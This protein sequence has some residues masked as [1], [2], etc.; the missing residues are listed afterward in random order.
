MAND[1]NQEIKVDPEELIELEFLEC[2][3]RRI[4]DDLCLLRILAGAYTKVGRYE[5]GL[6]LDLKLTQLVPEDALVWYNYGCSLALVQH[7]NEAL[8]ALAHAIALG[9][10]NA[11]WMSKDE[12]LRSLK[13]DKRFHFLLK[14]ISP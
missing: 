4:P 12:D 2:L 5:A 14:K 7:R 6:A 1:R 11:D 8:E 13:D 10:D 3:L 9:Y